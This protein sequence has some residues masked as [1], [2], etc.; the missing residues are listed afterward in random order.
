[1]NNGPPTV[2]SNGGPPL[3]IDTD[4][5]KMSWIRLDIADFKRGIA[6][7]DMELRGFYI[8][9]LVEMYDSKGRL[10]NDLALLGKRFGT[11]A[12][13]MR[14]VVELLVTE[15]KL[16]VAGE[17]L[18]NRRCDE[19]RERLIAEYCRRH[20]AAVK[21][22]EAKRKAE[23]LAEVSGKF[24]QSLA[25]VSPKQSPNSDKFDESFK[26]TNENSSVN[27]TEEPPQTWH[28]SD[29]SCG[30]KKEVRTKKEEKKEKLLLSNEPGL[31]LPLPPVGGDGVKRV[32]LREVAREAFK[33]W[34]AFADLHG[35][36][37]SLDSTFDTFAN[38]IVARMREHAT[39]QNREGYLAIWRRALCFIAKS[40]HCRGENDRGWQASLKFVCQKKSFAGLISGTYGNGATA[41]DPRWVL[42]PS[43]SSPVNKT[44]KPASRDAI[45]LILD[46][47]RR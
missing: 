7:M 40:R 28:S 20:A 6:N 33:E 41:L 19:E 29:H 39:E 24:Q 10:P 8:S 2:G 13:V 16:Y 11:T 36:P 1:M 3:S 15:G 38:E 27:S 46:G 47:G 43:E 4:D 30:E 9:M 22:E 45:D 25:E 37:G 44:A 26:K 32:S 42:S 12:R 31:G 18:R 5:V 23:S 14:R 17:T 34:Q 21:R 35:L